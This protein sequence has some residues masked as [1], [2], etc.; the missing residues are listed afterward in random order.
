MDGEVECQ[1]CYVMERHD[2]A[3]KVNV[4]PED[5]PKTLEH[6]YG[7]KAVV[8]LVV[9]VAADEMTELARLCVSLDDGNVT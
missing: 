3:L 5:Y 8:L 6:L 9:E 7:E 4:S 1:R 2:V